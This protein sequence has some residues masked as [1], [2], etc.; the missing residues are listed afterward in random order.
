M[1]HDILIYDYI[2]EYN[3]IFSSPLKWYIGNGMDM[4]TIVEELSEVC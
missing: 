2:K 1:G 4:I 3:N